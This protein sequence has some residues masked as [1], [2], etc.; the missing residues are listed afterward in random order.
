MYNKKY[1][2]IKLVPEQYE[3]EDFMQ[4]SE[5]GDEVGSSIDIDLEHFEI[6]QSGE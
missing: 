4:I 5:H 6:V 2:I 3:D 1:S